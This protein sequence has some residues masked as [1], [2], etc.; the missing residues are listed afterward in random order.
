M[1]RRINLNN[2]EDEHYKYH[3]INSYY[4]GETFCEETLS[5]ERGL[6][7]KYTAIGKTDVHLLVLEK[8]IYLKYGKFN[9]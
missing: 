9:I 7:Y 2:V 6:K 5:E 1:K 4:N 3:E 8:K